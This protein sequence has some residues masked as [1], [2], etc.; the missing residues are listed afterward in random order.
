M[1]LLQEAREGDALPDR[2]SL[3]GRAA[4]RRRQVPHLPQGAQQVDGRRVHREPAEAV[5][6]PGPQ[7]SAQ[8]ALFLHSLLQ[9]STHVF[10]L[11]DN[12]YQPQAL[13]FFYP[14]VPYV[15]DRPTRLASVCK[16]WG[17]GGFLACGWF[18]SCKSC[19]SLCYFHC[20]Q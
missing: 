11:D 14:R 20:R 7:V 19:L 16:G 15:D 8:T 6:P 2:A 4:R 3:R 9:K 12:H 18:S 5:Q 13:I 10:L 1:V 17:W